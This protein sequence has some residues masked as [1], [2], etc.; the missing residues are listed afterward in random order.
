[1][2]SSNTPASKRYEQKKNIPTRRDKSSERTRL[3]PLK[4]L[5]QKLQHIK[6]P[7]KYTTHLTGA[8][9]Q[10]F[11]YLEEGI[12]QANFLSLQRKAP[13]PKKGKCPLCKANP[14]ELKNSQVK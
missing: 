14:S 3:N 7:C 11:E 10:L 2:N 9:D 1:V 4:L 5:S 8:K 6:T 13:K 12:L